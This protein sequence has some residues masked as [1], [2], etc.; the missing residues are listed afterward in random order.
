MRD[1]KISPGCLAAPG[2]KK[3]NMIGSLRDGSKSIG[4]AFFSWPCLLPLPPICCVLSYHKLHRTS[5]YFPAIVQPRAPP[6]M[7]SEKK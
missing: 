2:L 6:R 5:S 7:F 3:A 1:K 4:R